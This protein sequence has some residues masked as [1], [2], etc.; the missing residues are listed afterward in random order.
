MTEYEFDLKK[1]GESKMPVKV[2]TILNILHFQTSTSFLSLSLV[3]F[4]RNM[5]F[6]KTAWKKRS[7]D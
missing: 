7:K 1:L 2:Q 3:S 6:E 5:C 4:L